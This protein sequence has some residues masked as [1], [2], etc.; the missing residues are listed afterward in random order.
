MCVIVYKPV[1]KKLPNLDI[2]EKCFNKNPDGAGFMLPVN[3]KVV[4]HKGFMTFNDFKKDIERTLKRNH[5]KDVTKLPIVLHFRISTQG[6]KQAGL[7]HPYPM[8]RDY[9][10]MRQ[11]ECE[12]N[13]ALCHNGIISSCST[14]EFYGGHYDHKTKSWVTGKYQ[15]L[16][17]N[18]TMTFIKD[19]ASLVIDNDIHFDKKKSKIELL[20]RLCEYSKLAIMTCNGNVTLI[21]DFK[22]KNGIYYSNLYHFDQPKKEKTYYGFRTRDDFNTQEEYMAYLMDEEY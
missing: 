6:G 17:Y 8:C 7:C 10:K 20:E 1:G 14:N 3:N 15:Q 9:A 21:G 12:S 16:N 22:E 19:Y 5:V 11:L 4:I 2:L 13:I 18:D